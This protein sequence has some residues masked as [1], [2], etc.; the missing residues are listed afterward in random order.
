LVGGL[1]VAP[2]ANIGPDA[3]VFEAVHGSAPKYAGQNKANPTAL[4]LSG[5]LMLRHIGRPDAAGRVEDA[6][7][8]VIAE[9]RSTTYDL[10]GSAGT[11]QF[12]DAIVEQLGEGVVPTPASA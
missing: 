3:A 5:V 4:I 9:G 7:R 6:L 8:T 2:G 1:G 10:G 11:S 12:A